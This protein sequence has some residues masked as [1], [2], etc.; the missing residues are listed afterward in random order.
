MKP[1]V[2][3]A[4]SSSGEGITSV[5]GAMSARGTKRKYRRAQGISGY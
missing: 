3:L 4:E 2:G 5:R 1:S